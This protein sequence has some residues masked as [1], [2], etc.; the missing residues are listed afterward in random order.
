M[1]PNPP[2]PP[3][4]ADDDTLR[5]HLAA[6]ETPALL[7][8]LVHL[9]GD[10][11]LLREQD[12]SNGWLLRPQGGL[13]PGAQEEIR[14]TALDVLSRLRDGAL[15]SPGPPDR[16]LLRQITGWALGGDVEELLPLVAE[17]IVPPGADPKAPDWHLEAVAP[18]RELHAAV[19]GAGMSGLL[20]A[21][22]LSQAGV[23]VTVYEKN[24]DVGGTWFENTYPG[25]RV[26]V[27]SHLYN[28]SFA[29]THDWPDHFCT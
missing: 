18:G 23:D 11:S 8:A 13:D 26:D 21:H 20:A 12:R 16:D 29:R 4:D 6:A 28:Y 7:M 9:T 25:C 14:A 2:I 5:R 15:T 27:A 17:E 1:T 19:I 24:P 22:R 3:I 10:T